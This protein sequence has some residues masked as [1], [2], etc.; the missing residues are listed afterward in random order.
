LEELSMKQPAY[1]KPEG[2]DAAELLTEEDEAVVELLTA[3]ERVVAEE[4]VTGADE[5]LGVLVLDAGAV[6][7]EVLLAVEE[8][9]DDEE[10][11][12]V[13]ETDEVDSEVLEELLD[14]EEEE[15]VVLETEVVNSELL[16]LLL[17]LL[18]LDEEEESELLLE[19]ADVVDWEVDDEKLSDEVDELEVWLW[20]SSV[21]LD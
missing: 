21:G 3:V 10:D 9:L 5:L 4:V 16:L 6:D 20:A 18:L 7:S 17:L 1:E 14:D 13:L 11:V 15:V 2:S 12:A 8:L 19:D